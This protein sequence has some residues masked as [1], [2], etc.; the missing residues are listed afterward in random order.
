MARTTAPF[1]GA[2]RFDVLA[3]DD[4]YEEEEE[5]VEEEP[6]VFRILHTAP[7]LVCSAES[8][9]LALRSQSRSDQQL[10]DG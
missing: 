3:S 6:Y 2:S 9:E 5:E 10:I 1:G 4:H 7:T 8:T